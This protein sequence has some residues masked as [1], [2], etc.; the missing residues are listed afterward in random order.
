VASFPSRPFTLPLDGR[1]L[2]GEEVGEGPPIFLV[3]GLSATRRYVVH[4]SKTLPR[5]GYRLISYDAR[6]H[7]QSDGAPPA[8]GYSYG[9]LADD[10]AAVVDARSQG[11]RPLF[12]GHSM[13]AQTA[14]AL[15]LAE[16]DRVAGLVIA[17]PVSMGVPYDDEVLAGW[18]AL[19][20]GLERDGPAGFMEV[21]SRRDFDPAW[22]EVILRITGE[23]MQLHRN[24]GALAEALRQV[25]RSMP[26]DG[27]AEL[28]FLDLPVLVVASHDAADPGHPYAIAEAWAEHLPRARLISEEEGE[29]PLA[30]QG[31]RLSREIAA[32]CA[33]PAV[34]ER[35]G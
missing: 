25:P 13:G 2:E 35:L 33:E 10:L 22:R 3:H 31:G 26:F 23:R 32:F 12:A 34:A 1:S 16:P 30:W 19:A 14:T 18:D 28:Q 11:S 7:G 8:G 24:P 9:E 4:G 5:E 27:L 20:G 6:A 17:G 15:A 29:S 21:Y